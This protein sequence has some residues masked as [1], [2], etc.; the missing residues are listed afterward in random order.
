LLGCCQIVA[1]MFWFV[2]RVFWVVA[3]LLLGRLLGC[4]SWLEIYFS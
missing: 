2:S 1:G 3:R 4:S